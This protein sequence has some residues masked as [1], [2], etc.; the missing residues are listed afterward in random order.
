MNNKKNN[1]ILFVIFALTAF[2]T[3]LFVMDKFY[4]SNN[5]AEEVIYVAKK[6]ISPKTVLSKDMFQSVRIPEDGVLPNYVTNLSDIKGKTLSGILL[7]GE[8]LTKNRLITE[9]DYEHNLEIK[10]ETDESSINVNNGEYINAYVLLEVNGELKTKKIF[11]N[12]QVRYKIVKSGT[13]VNSYLTMSVNEEEALR[14]MDAK[15]RGKIIIARNKNIDESGDID[16]DPNS[17]D[18]KNAVKPSANNDVGIISKTFEEGDTLENLAIRYKT[19]VER[20][21][22]LNG[23]NEFKVGD[24]IILPAN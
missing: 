21:K 16:Y 2:S 23:K 9:E 6:D 20:I 17:E 22:E 11:D 13:E 19:S 3:F 14:Y 12:K 5:S 10:I 4:F 24:Q 7:K 18:V 8:A 15:E 1:K